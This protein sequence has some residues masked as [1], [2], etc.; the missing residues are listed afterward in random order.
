MKS[1]LFGFL[2]VVCISIYSR[3]STAQDMPSETP[4]AKNKVI[5]IISH[6]NDTEITL[7]DVKQLYTLSKKLL[8]NGE[9]ASLVMMPME[10]S[11]TVKMFRF[12]LG[13]YPYQMQRKWD[14]VVFSGKGTA[15]TIYDSSAQILEFVSGNKGAV[16]YVS[17]PSDA[18]LTV[19]KE[20]VN[21]IAFI[22]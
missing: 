11:E 15:P 22:Q 12:L 16:G 8:P 14:R 21:V 2:I 6:L 9:R 10:A 18:E 7:S 19:L 13:A 3:S 1:T 4:S 20:T 17:I 5:V